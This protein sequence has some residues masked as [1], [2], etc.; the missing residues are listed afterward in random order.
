MPELEW[1]LAIT[2]FVHKFLIFVRKKEG[3]LLGSIAACFG[4]WYFENIDMHV[5]TALQF[6][7]VALMMYGFFKG[8]ERKPRTEVTI[9]AVTAG[10]M[11]V[12]AY[13]SWAGGITA[14]EL[15]STLCLLIGTYLLTHGRQR[16]G[17]LLYTIA[18]VFAT[19]LTAGKHQIVFA[20]FQ[21]FSAI[22]STLGALRKEKNEDKK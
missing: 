18:H 13:Y 16:Q 19:W 9:R 7:L 2:F 1:A 12:M 15:I 6:G 11:V 14:V 8:E 5:Y 3:W 20:I 4:W 10:V 22:I 21:G 17:W